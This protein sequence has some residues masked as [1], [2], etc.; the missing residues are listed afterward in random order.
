M[1]IILT[2]KYYKEAMGK[3]WKIFPKGYNFE[4]VTL[5][6]VVS[7]GKKWIV[8]SDGKIAK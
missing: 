4:K 7:N 2:E 1:K 5:E 3:T 8:T 6:L